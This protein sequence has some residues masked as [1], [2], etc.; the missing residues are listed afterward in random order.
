M[1]FFTMIG[2]R[3]RVLASVLLS[4][5]IQFTD[6]AA[7]FPTSKLVDGTR[8]PASNYPGVARILVDGA[9]CTGT[10]VGP[11]HILTAAHCFY[12]ERGR[13]MTDVSGATATLNGQTYGATRVTIHPTYVQ[14]EEACENGRVDAAILELRQDVQGLSGVPLLRSAPPVGT[15]LLLAGFGL[16]GTGNSGQTGSFPPNGIINIGFTNV[17]R[18]TGGYLEWEFDPGETNTASGDSGG[19]AFVN[20]NGVNTLSSITCGG[21]GN[22]EFGTA[23]LNTRVDIIASW[24]DSI[25]GTGTPRDPAPPPPAPPSGIVTL[26]SAQVGFFD[27]QDLLKLQGTVQVGTNFKPRGKSV[28]IDIEEFSDT[29]VLN[30]FGVK[31]RQRGFEFARLIGRQRANGIF[32]PTTVRFTIVLNSDVLYEKLDQR[33]PFDEDEL[34]PVELPVTITIDGRVYSSILTFHYNARSGLWTL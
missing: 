17:E 4:V 14:G 15:Q 6:A 32:R 22:S 10:I 31:S 24:I 11:R 26:T 28:R 13:P 3:L 8:V 9:L 12:D 21:D 2:S 18:V 20:V 29:F 30:R 7:D 23:S 33:F 16:E 19:P 27:R 1:V 25:V 5:F 34:P